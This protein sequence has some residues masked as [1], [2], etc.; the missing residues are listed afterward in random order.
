M[1]CW[2]SVNS[3]KLSTS[4]PTVTVQQP[5]SLNGGQRTRQSVKVVVARV[6]PQ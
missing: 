1:A 4:S 5:Q 3:P 6:V 2:M